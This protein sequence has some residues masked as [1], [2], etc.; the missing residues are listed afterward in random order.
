MFGLGEKNGR[1]KHPAQHE[2]VAGA[3]KNR[4]RISGIYVLF[5]YE[6]LVWSAI[7]TGRNK[8]GIVVGVIESVGRYVERVFPVVHPEH[9]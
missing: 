1:P 4:Q 3:P 5:F 7:T 8:A 9:H 6:G 2:S